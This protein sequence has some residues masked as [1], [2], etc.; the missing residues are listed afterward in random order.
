M[1]YLKSLKD[2]NSQFRSVLLMAT[3][4]T[5]EVPNPAGREGKPLS[6]APMTE[7]DV[8]RKLLAAKPEKLHALKKAKKAKTAK[9]E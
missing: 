1:R 3:K 9:K 6:L 5:K 7:S 8:L 4:K 2:G